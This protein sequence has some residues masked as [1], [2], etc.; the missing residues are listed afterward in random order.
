MRARTKKG[1]GTLV[2]L[3]LVATAC[4]GDDDTADETEPPSADA[5]PT[6][7]EPSDT[8]EATEDTDTTS[9]EESATDGADCPAD[10]NSLTYGTP[11][12]P[13]GLDPVLA[14]SAESTGITAVAQIYDTLMRWDPDAGAYTPRVAESLEPDAEFV[15]WTLTLREGISFGN[16]DPLTADAVK[17]SIERFNELSTGP[18]QSLT[19]KIT[20]MEVVDDL[21]LV[22][23]LNEGWSGFPFTLSLQP[24]MIVNTAVAEAAGESFAQNP[25]GAGVGAYELETFTTG[26]VTVLTAKDDYWNGP[27]CIG[28]LRFVPLPSDQARLEAFENGEFDVAY[29]MDPIV[30]DASSEY[31]GFSRYVNASSALLMNA[32]VGASSPTNDVRVR[33]GL[34]LAIDTEAVNQRAN[35]GLGDS[36]GGVMGAS[37]RYSLDVTAPTPDVEAA[38]TLFDAAKADGWDGTLRL[39]CD[40]G[41]E[42][43]ALAVAAQ[44]ADAGVTMDIEIVPTFGPLVDAIIVNQDFDTACWGLNIADEQPWVAFNNSLSSDSSANY[45]GAAN[46]AADKAIDDLRLAASDD[47]VTSALSEIQAQWNEVV[48]AVILLSTE[49]RVIHTDSVGGI[50]PSSNT[51][52]FFSDAYIE[53]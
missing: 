36:D 37:S 38:R 4:G 34:A 40:A 23:T 51:I 3:T 10:G 32:G 30:L 7:D 52:T 17:A 53:S 41:R 21:T 5:E 15:N 43:V 28:E 18:F 19:A 49:D 44:A 25:A 42:E 12:Q 6:A 27:P 14:A 13:A 45:G 1:L 39:I 50:E 9:A 48:P 29:L 8:G 16:G 31:P 26:E 46:D 22:I 33:Q 24:G 11:S 2:V 20:A 35:E 47:D